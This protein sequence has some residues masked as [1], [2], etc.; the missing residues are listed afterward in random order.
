MDVLAADCKTY[1]AHTVAFVTQFALEHR[2][3]A[4]VAD[5]AGELF[6]FTTRV[7]TTPVFPTRVFTTRVFTT[8]VF[9][10][11]VFTTPV[12]TQ[13]VRFFAGVARGDVMPELV[14]CL[15]LQAQAEGSG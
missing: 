6:N 5:V 9:T 12:C 3:R 4:A 7:F 15:R 11:H 14:P 2:L 1:P 10:T 8:R 13:P